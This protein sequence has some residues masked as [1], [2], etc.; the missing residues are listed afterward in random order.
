MAA[1]RGGPA[2]RAAGGAAVTERRVP[3]LRVLLVWAV[4]ELLAA[5]QARRSSGD[6]VLRGWLETASHPWVV[7]GRWAGDVGSVIADG[8]GITRHLVGSHLGL[9]LQL[10]AAEEHNLLLAEDLRAQREA[11]R[12]QQSTASLA[13]GALV[14]RC[15]FRNP[16]LGRMQLEAGSADGVRHDTA[17]IAVGGLAGRVVRLGRHACWLELITHPASAVAVRTEDG[18]VRGLVTGTG[19]DTLA[20]EFVPR[21]DALVRGDLLVTSSADGIYPPGIPVAVVS[22]VRESEEPFLEVMARPTAELTTARVAVLLPPW[23]PTAAMEP[24]P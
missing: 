3:V 8:T 22:A 7:A 10:E 15:S 5:A 13:G 12:L 20:V 21:N 14:V 11:V 24:P 16:V 19:G 9:R 4:L 1:L 6:S 17:A 2:E 18:Q 23:A